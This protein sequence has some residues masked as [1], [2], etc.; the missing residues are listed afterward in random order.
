MA[1]EPGWPKQIYKVHVTGACTFN[2]VQLRFLQFLPLLLLPLLLPQL[3]PPLLPG[4]KSC[5][6]LRSVKEVLG[7]FVVFFWVRGSLS[8]WTETIVTVKGESIEVE[9]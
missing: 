8:N 4:S 7:R 5:K 9:V 2:K 6:R 1:V 3:L